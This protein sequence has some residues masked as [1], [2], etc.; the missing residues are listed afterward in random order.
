M[1]KMALKM[2]CLR[3]TFP[4]KKF[5]VAGHFNINANHFCLKAMI[6][7][8]CVFHIVLSILVCF[9]QVL[10]NRSLVCKKLR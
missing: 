10:L 5:E 9:D 7:K 3:R 4:K 8:R 6:T 2:L 1:L